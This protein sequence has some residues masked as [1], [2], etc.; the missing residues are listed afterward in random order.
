LKI[1]DLW[2]PPANRFY[3]KELLGSNLLQKQM[4]ASIVFGKW[5][6]QAKNYFDKKDS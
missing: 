2:S 3:K 6:I 1:E 4:F 5:I